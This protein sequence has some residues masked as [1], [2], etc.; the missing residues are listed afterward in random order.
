[1]EINPNVVERLGGA[2]A[3]GVSSLGRGDALPARRVKALGQRV[4]FLHAHGVM[5]AIDTIDLTA[6]SDRDS[7]LAGQMFDN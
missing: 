1:M 2:R 7:I 3:I 6:R 4:I 5:S